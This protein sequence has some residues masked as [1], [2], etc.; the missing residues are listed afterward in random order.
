MTC[1]KRRYAGEEAQQQFW[2]WQRGEARRHRA[3]M[4]KHAKA[5]RASLASLDLS[6]P[7]SIVDRLL[8]LATHAPPP[9]LAQKQ[10]ETAAHATS[11]S[12][13]SGAER[14]RE[15]FAVLC[16]ALED[17]D[18]EGTPRALAVRLLTQHMDAALHRPSYG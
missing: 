5:E 15:A 16:R 17:T 6:D 11:K 3:R 9:Q 13:S 7:N 8:F 4:E 18:A 14:V 10:K 2:E 1:M 12:S